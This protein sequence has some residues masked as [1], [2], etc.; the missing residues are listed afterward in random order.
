[1]SKI[2]NKGVFSFSYKT[3]TGKT[4]SCFMD[5]NEPVEANFD[6]LELCYSGLVRVLISR[7]KT[8][9]ENGKEKIVEKKDY[10]TVG[11]LKPR[12]EEDQADF[13]AACNETR[14]VSQKRK[15]ELKVQKKAQDR[16]KEPLKRTV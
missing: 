16:L 11:R 4:I 8:I 9:K 14:L 15:Q 2:I 12:N 10:V 5:N 7:K 3:H 6:E 1:M 13:S